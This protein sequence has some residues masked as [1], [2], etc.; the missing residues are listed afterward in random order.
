MGVLGAPPKRIFKTDADFDEEPSAESV[1]FDA[2]FMYVLLKDGRELKVPLIL[3]PRLYFA[4][5]EQRE[6]YELGEFG[7]DIHWED[8]DEDILVSA[9]LLAPNEVKYY[10][11]ENLQ[12]VLDDP[13]LGPAYQHYRQ[14]LISWD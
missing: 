8:L 1:R 4:T 2:N 10:M 7:E 13:I 3:F 6:A 14:R 5:P 12:R 11:D 9:L